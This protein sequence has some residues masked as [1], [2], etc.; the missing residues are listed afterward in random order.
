[1]YVNYSDKYE[2]IINMKGNNP[3]VVAH[4]FTISSLYP[5]VLHFGESVYDTHAIDCHYFI[6]TIVNR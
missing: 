5:F 3:I 2:W 1:M 6:I 4:M